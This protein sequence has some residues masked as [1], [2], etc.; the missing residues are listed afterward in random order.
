MTN[1]NVIPDGSNATTTSTQDGQIIQLQ[2]GDSA[3]VVGAPVVDVVDDRVRFDNFGTVASQGAASTVRFSGQDGFLRNDDDASVDAENT[4]VEVSGDARILNDG[5]ISGAVNAVN[6]VNGGTSSGEIFNGGTISSDSRAVNIGGSDIRLVNNGDIVG[7]GDQRNG[8]IYT[9]ATSTD[10][11]IVN[12]LGGTIDAGEGNN[13]SALSLETGAVDGEEINGSVRNDGTIQGRG[14]AS[15][16]N[17]I[18]DGVRVYSTVDGVTLDGS[19]LNRGT[20]AGSEDS[21]AAVGIRIEDGVALD[22]SILNFG[23][24]R[25]SQTAIDATEAGGDLRIV[26]TGII[27]GDVL[28][29]AGDDRFLSARSTDDLTVDA[30]AGNDVVITGRGDDLIIDGAGNDRIRAGQGEDTLSYENAVS[31]VSVDLARGRSSSD[32]GFD[33]EVSDAPLSSLTTGQSPA[34]LVAEAEAGNLYFNIHTEDFPGGEIRGQLGVASDETVDGVRTLTLEADLDAS[35]EPNGASDSPATGFGTV[36]ITVDGENVTYSSSL[37]VDGIAPAD[38]LPV[39]GVSSIHLHNA[40]AGTNGPVI[41]DIVQ[42]AGGDVN[43]DIAM[44]SGDVFDEDTDMDRISGVENVIG[45][46]GDDT[47]TGSNG[48]NELS[49]GAGED[50]LNGGNGNDVLRGDASG[51]GERITVTVTNSAPEGGTFLTPVWFGFHDGADFDLYTRGEAVSVGLERLAEDGNFAVIAEEFANETGGDGVG[52]AVFGFEGAGGPLDPGETGSFT[53]TVDPEAVGQGY[54]TWATMVIPSN[55]AFLAAPGNPL[56]DPIFDEDGNFLGPLT[57]T[58]D[59]NDVLDAGTEV[60]NE[61]EAAFLNQTGPNQGTTEN[62]VVTVHP[63]FN[64]SEGNPDAGPVNILGGTTA[65]GAVIDPVLGD[66]T[67][68]GGNDQLIE[69]RV[70]RAAGENDVLNGGRGDD[71]LIG[72]GGDDLLTGGAGRDVFAFTLQAGT[73]ADTVTD[74]RD[75]VDLLDVSEFGFS[76]ASDVAISDEGGNAVLTFAE[77]NSVTLNGVSSS[78]IDDSDFIFG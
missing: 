9:D 72:G 61:I 23:T 77:G 71:T 47:I 25:G 8:T 51:S 48:S 56:T 67:R 68:N 76:S 78:L 75:G 5:T 37:S 12:Q 42:D 54:F 55:D 21:V 28:L 46:D 74:F 49:G 64:G 41:T 15:E 7:T 53:V 30:G 2:D 59:G 26:N 14:D 20:I 19:I 52:G 17:Q 27:D 22:G 63:G 39:A 3:T 44:G 70:E 45:S 18:G 60:N 57:I 66:F 43:G 24:I 50:T 69:I 10:Y 65:P 40:P 62:G 73:S 16:G 11:S 13:G 33:V 34:D 29:G 36:T 31:G 6:F 1:R 38:L 4:G 32:T 35:Q 58:R